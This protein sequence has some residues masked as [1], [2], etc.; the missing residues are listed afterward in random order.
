MSRRKY[1]PTEEMPISRI[2]ASM[3]AF[4]VSPKAGV[5]GD[6]LG[7]S[8]RSSWHAQSLL[9]TVWLAVI[10]VHL[11]VSRPEVLTFV[12][13]MLDGKQPGKSPCTGRRGVRSMSYASCQQWDTSSSVRPAG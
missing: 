7:F 2:L 4:S 11:T 1:S 12:L 13:R 9:W 8:H 5:G 10:C 6:C 3:I